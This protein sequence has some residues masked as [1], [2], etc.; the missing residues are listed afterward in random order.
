MR[1]NATSKERLKVNDKDVDDVTE[2]TYL[3]S[4]VT[5]TGG[6]EDEVKIRVRK[7]NAAFIQLYSVWIAKETKKKPKIKMGITGYETCRKK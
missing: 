2:F 3:G 7:A 6:T 4:V 5:T 1:I